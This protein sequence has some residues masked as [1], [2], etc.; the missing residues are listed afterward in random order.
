M[1]R[2]LVTDPLGKE[3]L[4]SD[5]RENIEFLKASGYTEALVFFGFGW[6]EHFYKDQWKEIPMSLDDLEKSVR[7]AESNGYGKL[8]NDNLYFTVEEIPIRLNYSYES[9]IRLSYSKGNDIASAIEKRW[10]TRG[11]LTE[12]Q[13]S[14]LYNR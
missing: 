3:D 13:N 4:W 7:K 5:L 6:G 12:F 8:G 11:W 1:N 9:V 2:E 14:R 10:N